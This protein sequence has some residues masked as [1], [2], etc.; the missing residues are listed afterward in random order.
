VGV[1][2]GG[3]GGGEKRI[4]NFSG[5]KMMVNVPIR[6]PRTSCKD[7]VIKILEVVVGWDRKMSG[8]VPDSID[9]SY[10]F[11]HSSSW[12]QKITISFK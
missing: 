6:R 1:G 4:Q 5:E 10:S 12:F 7:R 2:G 8:F 11:Y 9:T 3:G